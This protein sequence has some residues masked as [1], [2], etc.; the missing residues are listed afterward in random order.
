[1]R[2]VRH[3]ASPTGLLTIV[4]SLVFGASAATAQAPAAPRPNPPAVSYSSSYGLTRPAPA[5][6]A[7]AARVA[8]PAVV[9]PRARRVT[10]HNEY[11][12]ADS[13]HYKS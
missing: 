12:R 1:M 10:P 5:V 9:A 13:Y 3:L 6:A 7:P 2:Y 11:G 8:R 4:G